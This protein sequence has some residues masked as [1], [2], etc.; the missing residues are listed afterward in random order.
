MTQFVL[1]QSVLPS[2]LFVSTNEIFIFFIFIFYQKELILSFK[3]ARVKISGSYLKISTS[4]E[5][6]VC[7]SKFR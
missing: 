1:F 5:I 2:V 4:S 7:K 6:L 3:L